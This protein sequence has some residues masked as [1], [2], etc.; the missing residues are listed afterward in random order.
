MADDMEKDPVIVAGAGQA[1]AQLAQ[2]LRQEGYA[3]PI[4]LIGEEPF[5]PYE[6]PP[7]SK[8]YLAGKRDAG[9]LLLR[10]PEYWSQ[11]QVDIVLGARVT[12][13]DPAMRR[14]AL[15]DGATLRYRWLVWAAGGRPRR[16]ACPGADL[17]GIHYVR[18]IADIDR[19]KGDLEQPERRIVIIGGGYIGLE[20]AAVLRSFGHHVSL[21]EMQD[22]LLARVTSDIVSDFFL[23]LHAHHGINVFLST[24]VTRVT[25]RNGRVDGVV[26]ST[27]GSLPA[28]LVVVGVGIVPNVEPL[29][30]AGISCPNGVSVDRFC[31]TSDP[32]ILAIGDCALHPNIYADGGSV[33]LESVQNAIDQA[34]VAAS[35]IL[36][37]PKPYSA[38]PWFW[39]DQYGVKMQTAGLSAGYDRAVVRGAFGKIPFSV[40]YL[41]AGRLIA[42]DCM[43]APKDFVQSRALVM[44]RAAIDWQHLA[45]PD[46]ELKSLMRPPDSP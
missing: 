40:A 35:V 27:G 25:G 44:E 16:L 2:C 15:E 31:R 41:R 21:V 20:A 38:M 23:D 14:V 36:G 46:I 29:A 33:R 9:R 42:M 7:L 5:P 17:D 8:D 43:G 32:R 1:G 10:K 28:D 22:R 39:S 6:R 11:R 26:L 45:D 13:V 4:T 3:G 12:G 18:S 34:N 24:G 30:A 37:R 19:L